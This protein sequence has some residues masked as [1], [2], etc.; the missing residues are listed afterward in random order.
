LLIGDL[1]KNDD[2]I[3]EYSKPSEDEDDKMLNLDVILDVDYKI[4]PLV[5]KLGDAF[6]S[7][8]IISII[9]HLVINIFLEA[10]ILRFGKHSFVKM[11]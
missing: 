3:F 6:G 7:A 5:P 10:L 8:F 11:I 9:G 2:T 1:L 4:I